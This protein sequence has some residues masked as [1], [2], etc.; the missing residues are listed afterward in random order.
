MVINNKSNSIV[1]RVLGYSFASWINCLISFISTPII[2]SLFEPGELGKVNLFVAYANMVIPFI[3]LGF[4]QAF[5]RY[6]NEHIEGYDSYTLGKICIYI[7]GVLFCFSALIILVLNSYLSRKIV[8]YDNINITICMIVYVFSTY[9][10]RYTQ[11]D[12]RMKN[13]VLLYS[14]QSIIVTFIIKVSFVL[15]VL[16]KPSA[17]NAIIF[18]S[19]SFL[20]AAIVFITIYIKGGNKRKVVI[21]KNIILELARYSLPLFPTVM[22]VTLNAS[23]PQLMLSKYTDYSSIGIYTNALTIASIISLIQAGLNTFW[24]PFVYENYRTEQRKLQKMQSLI[25]FSMFAFG[26]ILILF[27]A[28]IYSLLVNKQYWQSRKIFALLLISPVC[29]TISE[30]LGIG[31]DLSKRTY[32]KI[33]VYISSILVNYL[34]CILLIPK[35]GVVGAAVS[36]GISAIIMLCTKAFCGERYFKCCDNYIKLLIG[37][38]LFALSCVINVVINGFLKYALILLVFLCCSVVYRSEI[39]MLTKFTLN[40]ITDIFKRER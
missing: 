20:I 13:N 22:M 38:S 36:S 24:A 35:F 3:Y 18:R 2:T 33:P 37:M 21:K 15:V 9:I 8:G 26:F 4:D 6:Y 34:S 31:I 17:E 40:Y 23:L 27:Q 12:A 7:S 28:P 19:A 32:L 16:I 14:I 1:N 5:A 25:S 11:L 29:T 30:T 10:T 39:R